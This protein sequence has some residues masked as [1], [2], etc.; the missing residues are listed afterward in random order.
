MSA[1]I[2]VALAGIAGYGDA[3]LEAMLP[4]QQALGARL[5]GVVDPLPQR[6]RRL[7]ELNDADVPVHATMD[8]LFD[9]SAVDL[10]LIVTPIHLHA[11]QTCLALA[12]GA[13]VLCEKPIAGTLADV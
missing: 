12:R 1:P 3:Y 11:A 8:E 9:R 4:K 2:R 7:A 13:N 5:V 6:C 10:M